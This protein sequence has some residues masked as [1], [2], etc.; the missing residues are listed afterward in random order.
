M[1]PVSLPG[2]FRCPVQGE[3]A[4]LLVDERGGVSADQQA[5]WSEEFVRTGCRYAVCFGPS[6]RSWDDAIDMVG[7][8]D[9]VEGRAAPFVMT[10]WH[11]DEPFE[12]TVGFFAE[13]TRFDDWS[14]DTYV[15]VVMGGSDA[16]E[17]RVR[18][19]VRRGF[20]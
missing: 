17:E 19:I 2:A 1:T 13:Q 3:Y 16:D 11:D 7:V 5:P 12:E 9:E 8:V 15:V 14:T 18:Q 10:T 6:S 20:G 4:L